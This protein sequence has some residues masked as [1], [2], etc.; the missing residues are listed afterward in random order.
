MRS[1]LC[2]LAITYSLF[3]HAETKAPEFVGITDWIDAKPITLHSLRGKVVLIDFWD[4]SCINCIRTIPHIERLHNEYGSQ[5]LTVIGIH[6]PEFSFEHERDNVKKA[7]SRFGI[8]YPV[9]MDN[10][11]KTWRAYD[12]KYWPT[13][14]VVDKEG[15]I[16]YTHIGEGKYLELENKIRK[17]L[18]LEPLEQSESE[19]KRLPTTGEIYLG[20][21][22][23]TNY[24]EESTLQPHSVH[25]YSLKT[26]LKDD[27]VGLQGLFRVS[28]ENV[29]SAGSNCS[30]SVNF[31]GNR[32]FMVLSGTSQEPITLLL[33][34]KPVPKD[35]YT[36]DMDE[37]GSI[38]IDESR[39]YDLINLK[40]DMKRRTLTINL[41]AGISCYSFTFGN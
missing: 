10:D 30:I 37:H 9:A 28:A 24:A 18:G 22:R 38:L 31:L 32:V 23:A 7:I 16:R 39:K 4:Y 20:S 5:G 33:D 6:T 12:N 29:T 34:G 14:Y 19:L 41:P 1:L 2:A 3:C 35:G 27:E 40:G 36:K 17:E 13:S 11:Y 25:A 26:P 21:A 15:I 8:T